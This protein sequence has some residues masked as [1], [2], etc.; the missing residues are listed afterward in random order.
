MQIACRH[1][2][3]SMLRFRGAHLRLEKVQH[4][5]LYGARLLA[6]H[7]LAV[8]KM[9]HVGGVSPQHQVTGTFEADSLHLFCADVVAVETFLS[10]AFLQFH[11]W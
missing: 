10:I 3:L 4:V 8:C 9:E 11:F 7:Q 6:I 2:R 1:A 5:F